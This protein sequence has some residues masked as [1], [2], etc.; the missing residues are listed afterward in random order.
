MCTH[1]RST[2]VPPWLIAMASIE[3]LKPWRVTR[4]SH[5]WSD[6]WTNVV[7]EGLLDVGGSGFILLRY[8][9]HIWNWLRR[10]CCLLLAGRLR[11]RWFLETTLCWFIM[12]RWWVLLL[13]L[14]QSGRA[15]ECFL[16][17]TLVTIITTFSLEILWAM[18]SWCSASLRDFAFVCISKFVDTVVVFLM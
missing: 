6:Q 10:G 15:V 16:G 7:V 13:M 1:L 14:V 3:G 17:L 4:G 11:G 8:F 9:L 2:Q 5:F 18:A 12:T